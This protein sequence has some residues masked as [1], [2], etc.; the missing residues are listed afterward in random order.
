MQVKHYDKVEDIVNFCRLKL[1]LSTT[2]DCP[3]YDAMQ[4]LDPPHSEWE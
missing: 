2:G 4:L 1:D 3:V